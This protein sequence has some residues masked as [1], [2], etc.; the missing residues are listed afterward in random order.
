M[1]KSSNNETPFI[2]YDVYGE[3]D[4][5]ISA[6]SPHRKW[7]DQTPSRYAYRCLPLV[8]ANQHG[9]FIEAP[10]SF[11]AI[12]NGGED[13]KDIEIVLDDVPDK[14][15]MSHFGFGV[16][17]FS[18]PYLFRTPPGI[19]LLAKGP[20]NY[21]KD[22]I[23]AL[24]GII[25]TDWSHYSFT[26]NWRFTRPNHEIRF[27]KF[28]PIC[29]IVPVNRHLAPSLVPQLVN[30]KEHPELHQ[31]H[32]RWMDSR[33][34]FNND[35]ATFEPEAVAQ[36]WQRSYMLGRDIDGNSFPDH[37]TRLSLRE[38]Q[39]DTTQTE[40]SSADSNPKATGETP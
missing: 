11:R 1:N 14:R 2:A 17:T 34:K 22:G 21:H 18:I 10:F 4:Y 20:A 13:A 16:L 7:M 39:R 35:L 29:M 33:E 23:Q 12:W 9:W 24:E 5:R 31:Q 36:G 32:T 38:F 27:E 3:T 25:E 8:I 40:T 19:N 30:L 15:V 6:A 26:M 37:Q 28:E